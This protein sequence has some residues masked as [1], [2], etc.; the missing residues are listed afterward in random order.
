MKEE[1]NIQ[2]PTSNAQQRTNYSF[3]ESEPAERV[4]D[5]VF[6]LEDQLFDYAAAIVRLVEEF[7]KTRAGNHVAAQLLR[8]GTFPL[9]NHGEAESAESFVF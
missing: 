5:R 4:E 7:P 6:D 2:H 8:S 3:E 9:P 1:E